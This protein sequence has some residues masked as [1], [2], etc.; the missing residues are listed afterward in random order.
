MAGHWR[1]DWAPR[2]RRHDA[3]AHRPRRLRSVARPARREL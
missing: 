2:H 1:G 3:G